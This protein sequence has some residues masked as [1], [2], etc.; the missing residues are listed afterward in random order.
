MKNI[1]FLF[2]LGAL[3]VQAQ[4]MKFAAKID[5]RNS[6]TITILGPKKFKQVIVGKDGKFSDTFT[7]TP[8]MHQLGDGTEVTMLYLDNG[9]DLNL[10]MD[11]KMF[12]ESI[13]FTGKG[14][15]ENNFLAQKALIDERMEEGFMK[16]KSEAEITESVAKRNE[17]LSGM[18]ADEELDPTFKALAGRVVL[19]EA[20]QIMQMFQQT[21][22]VNDMVGK[23]SPS[24]DYEN[25]K[26]GTTKLEDLRGKYVYIDTWA[27]WCGPCLR[28]IPSMKEIEKKYHGKNITFVGVSIDAKK[29][30]Q[31]WKDMV[32]KKEL[33]GV[34]VFA[35]NDWNSQ[36]IKDYGITGIPRF[37][38]L[39]PKG[40]VVDANAPRPS[41]PAL[42]ELLDKLL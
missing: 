27:T 33:G 31:K 18:L 13:V 36:F 14:S 39:D 3:G 5:N 37:I 20:N 28:E 6:D 32:T 2:L 30:H 38:L 9:Y 19:A 8:G 10:T 23:P 40:N 11:A 34:Q 4:S 35:D 7:V 12:D 17:Q 41:D 22:A 15:K 25:H 42:Q 1:V 29:D 21:L 16:L 24:F 26:G